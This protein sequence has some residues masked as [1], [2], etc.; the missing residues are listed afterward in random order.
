VEACIG[1][2]VPGRPIGPWPRRDGRL[3]QHEW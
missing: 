1:L 3:R 2:A